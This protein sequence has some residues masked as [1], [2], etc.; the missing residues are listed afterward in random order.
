MQWAVDLQTLNAKFGQSTGHLRLEPLIG[1]PALEVADIFRA[2][3]P[4]L[5]KG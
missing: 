3:R 2:Q 5:S 4:R 1:R